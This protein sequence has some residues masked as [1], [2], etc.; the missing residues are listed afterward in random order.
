MNADNIIVMSHGAVIEQGTHDDLYARDG[1]YR[2]LVDAQRISAEGTG[3]E[4][5]TPA[6]VIEAEDHIN[7]VASSPDEEISSP[8]RKT[9]TEQSKISFNE[10]NAGVVA[11]T[12]YPLFYLL[13]KV[14]SY[15]T[16]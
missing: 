4:D 6:E 2:G 7:R 12:K 5:R 11:R 1:M 10:N 8:I 3:D 13:K 9:T 15:G 14:W 16:N